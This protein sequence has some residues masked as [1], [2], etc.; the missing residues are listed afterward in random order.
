MLSFNA[1]FRATIDVNNAE[2]A[3][4]AWAMRAAH[5]CEKD[6]DFGNFITKLT[7]GED[8]DAPPSGMGINEL[9]RNVGNV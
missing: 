7:G 5:M 4:T 6:A 3:K 1:L 9:M 8:E 2:L